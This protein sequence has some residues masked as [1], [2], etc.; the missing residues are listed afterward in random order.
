MDF[1]VNQLVRS[2]VVLLI[3]APISPG[4]PRKRA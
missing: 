2:A 3:G 1:N 4:N